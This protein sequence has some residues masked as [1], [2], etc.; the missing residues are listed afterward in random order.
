[1][2]LAGGKLKFVSME[3]ITPA[4]APNGTLY[5]DSTNANTPTYKNF[6]GVSEEIGSG[7]GGGANFLLKQIGISPIH[8]H[9]V[10]TSE[11]LQLLLDQ[12]KESGALDSSEHE[13]IKNVFD[14]NDR[15]VKKI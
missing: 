15:T 2:S 11:E 12:G 13:L 9:E 7:G 4:E 1:M 3:P 5:I 10:H 8:G 6:S 14:F